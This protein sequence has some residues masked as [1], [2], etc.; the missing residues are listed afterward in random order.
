M[1]GFHDSILTSQISKFLFLEILKLKRIDLRN[2][3][4]RTK[5]YIL[6]LW[7][8]TQFTL[9]KTVQVLFLKSYTHRIPIDKEH[10]GLRGK[11]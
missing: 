7:C 4:L 8:F 11:M 10:V 6:I 9:R 1:L 3:L 2:K 5:R